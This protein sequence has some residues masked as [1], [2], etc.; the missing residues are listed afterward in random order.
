MTELSEKFTQDFLI[1]SV[2][3]SEL[4][5]A[6]LHELQTIY[7]VADLYDILEMMDAHATMLEY[8]RRQEE[9]ERKNS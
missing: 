9:L 5:L 3:T 4:R 2:V 8:Q 1:L 6:S 7:S